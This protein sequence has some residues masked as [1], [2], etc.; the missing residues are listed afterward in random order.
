MPVQRVVFLPKEIK[1]LLNAGHEV[2]PDVSFSSLAFAT[3][4]L[5]N[6][7]WLT[8]NLRTETVQTNCSILS[9]GLF[10]RIKQEKIK[11]KWR[12]W[13]IGMKRRKWHGKRGRG[14]GGGRKGRG[15]LQRTLNTTLRC[16]SKR[17]PQLAGEG[18][19]GLMSAYIQVSLPGA[20]KTEM[21][22]SPGD[23]TVQMSS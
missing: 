4:N 8:V 5:P 13:K 20:G 10:E 16:G 7:V 11:R 22:G 21:S 23:C 6:P 9:S 2:V 3:N 12:K 1:A 17:S 19:I 18:R 15:L 14:G